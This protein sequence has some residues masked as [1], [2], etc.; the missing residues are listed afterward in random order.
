MSVASASAAVVITATAVVVV[1]ITATAAVVVAATV[2]VATAAAYRAVKASDYAENSRSKARCGS[3]EDVTAVAGV[4][5]V[6]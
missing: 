4:A 3:A 6:V 1:I 2:I 5:S